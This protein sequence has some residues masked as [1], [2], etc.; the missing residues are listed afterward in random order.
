[1][2]LVRGG[3]HRVYIFYPPPSL[4][5]PSSPAIDLPISQARSHSRTCTRIPRHRLPTYHPLRAV[6]PALLQELQD[7]PWADDINNCLL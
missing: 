7:P 6:D 4:F 5:H 2:H 1:M 3:K